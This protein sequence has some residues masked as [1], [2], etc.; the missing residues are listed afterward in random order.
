VK[1]Q[2]CLD[3]GTPQTNGPR[4]ERCTT[5]TP[6]YD[7]EYNRNQAIVVST[8]GECWLCGEDAKPNDPWTADHIIPLALGGSNKL[9]NLAKAH[10]SCNSRRG[11]ALGHAR[12]PRGSKMRGFRA[13]AYPV[14]PTFVC[15]GSGVRPAKPAVALSDNARA[16]A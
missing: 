1:R 16:Q 15:T 5:V 7:A 8:P 9:S 14:A 3:C 4:C 2:P 6:G 13:R 12:H 11:Q 10:L